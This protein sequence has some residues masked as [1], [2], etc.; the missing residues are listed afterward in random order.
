[1]PSVLRKSVARREGVDETHEPPPLCAAGARSHSC[2][3][4]EGTRTPDLLN[5]IQTRSQLRYSPTKLFLMSY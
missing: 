1:M 3:G 4:A 2:G 5:A